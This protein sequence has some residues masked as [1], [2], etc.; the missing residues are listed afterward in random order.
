MAFWRVT[1]LHAAAW[2]TGQADSPSG[3]LLR[4]RVGH[5]APS[6]GALW[7]APARRLDPAGGALTV[8]LVTVGVN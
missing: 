7:Q 1:R 3:F 8:R 4:V 2:A 6:P 5:D